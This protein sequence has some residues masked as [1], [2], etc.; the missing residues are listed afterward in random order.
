MLFAKRIVLSFLPLHMA[1][2]NNEIQCATLRCIG[3]L[4]EFCFHHF[5]EHQQQLS[6]QL[7][8]IEQHRNL[9]Q[10]IINPQDDSLIQQV[11]QWER[12]SIE[13][14]KQTAQ[15]IRQ[16][17]LAHTHENIISNGDKVDQLTEQMSKS[18][19]IFIQQTQISLIDKI[20]VQF[21]GKYTDGK[22]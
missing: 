16:S 13:K 9:L 19:N 12:E 15:E 1:T 21:S 6:K 10:Q 20:Q 14:I 3:C 7:D 2:P 4:Q 18:S 5:V 11:D 17:V 8:E 22:G